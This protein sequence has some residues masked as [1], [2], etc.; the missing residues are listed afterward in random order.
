M[1]NIRQPALPFRFASCGVIAG[2]NF[3]PQLAGGATNIIVTANTLY[4]APL[5]VPNLSYLTMIAINVG[6]L[7]AASN[8][9]LGIY[10]DSAGYPGALV[11][12]I[13]TVSTATTGLKKL[14]PA[15]AIKLVPGV[16]WPAVVFSHGPTVDGVSQTSNILP[17]L[18]L[19][20]NSDTNNYA[21]ISVAFTYA[22]LPDPFTA[23]GAPV[24]ATFTRIGVQL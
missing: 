22:A 13:G 4:A 5:W 20:S 11:S 2:A 3:T 21:G 19:T 1:A 24:N 12:D 6:A 23:G 14:V 7:V 9:R 17:V 10:K 15:A 18:G 8:A 16:Y